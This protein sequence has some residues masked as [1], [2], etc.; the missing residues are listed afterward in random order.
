MSQARVPAWISVGVL[1]AINILLAFLL[2]AVLFYYLDINPLDAADI[3]WYGA[4]GTGEGIG[5]TLYYATGFIFTGLAVAVAFHAGLFNI[6]GEGQAYIGGLGVGLVC[7]LLGD[8]LP[9]ALLLPLA[10]IVG[11]LFGA[12]WAFI[13]AWLQAKRGSHIVITTIMFNF[14]ASS[15]MAYLLVDIFKPAGS[16]AAE[17]KVF[18]EAS[19]LPKM[20]ELASSFGMAMPN[21]PLNISFIWA[22]I[23]AVLVWVFIWHTRWG[24]E[25]RSVGASQ[26][27]SAYAGISYPKVVI[28]AMVISGMLAGFFA[29]NV[30][31]GELHQVKLN[32]VEG[33]GFTG[34]AVALMGRN[35]P[36]GVI[37]ASLLFGFLYQGGAEL[38]FE[39]GV[40][41]NIVVVLQGLVILFCG[42]LE[43]MMRPRLEQLY[44][45]L[46][47]RPAAEAKGV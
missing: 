32:F 47:S 9:F 12:A 33:F 27:A 43:H 45:S 1:P 31:Q 4:F 42:A 6:G 22:L 10:I 13:P 20:S 15:L 40:D 21:S 24:Y 28:L 19:W 37:I 35:H 44:L 39:F 26:S 38:S 36:V 46:A 18:A 14:I 5:F 17:S 7:L 8:V 25:I 23:C 3:M 41:R 30:L 34:I 29:L 16:M 11:G 2:S